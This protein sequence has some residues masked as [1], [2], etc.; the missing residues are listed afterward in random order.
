MTKPVFGTAEWAKYNA[1]CMNG[2]A[3]NC[4]YCYAKVNALRFK[5]KT[6]VTWTEEIPKKKPKRFGKMDGA[7]MFPTT[8][9]ITPG[10]LS[11]VIDYLGKLLRRGND[12]LVVSKPHYECIKSICNIFTSYRSKILFRFTIGSAYNKVLKFWEP[13]A[14]SFEERVKS[15]NYAFT[16]GYK[17]SVSCEPML[18]DKID[19][20]INIVF[21][22]ITDAI[23]LGKMNH[24]I[25]R[26]KANGQY[27]EEMKV[28][29]RDLMSYQNYDENIMALY[30]RYKDN[31]KI[32]WKES[33]KKVVGIEVPTE[34]GL[35][36]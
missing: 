12:V 23:W 16:T 3:H 5:R 24:P 29:L 36:I 33:I 8:H 26:I 32:K 30:V 14:P 13:N 25:D 17:T 34:K 1:N 9:D 4:K 20:V 10:N 7:I 18:D 6:A 27:D 31:P 28:R 2:C 15:L 19:D 21:M 11:Y 22:Y 35:D